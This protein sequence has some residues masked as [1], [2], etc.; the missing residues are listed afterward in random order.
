MPPGAACV[1][2]EVA[3]IVLMYLAACAFMRLAG[4]GEP[5]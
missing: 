5:I 3:R 4:V 2:I 1:I